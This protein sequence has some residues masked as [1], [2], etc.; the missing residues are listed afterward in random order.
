MRPTFACQRD[1]AF[2]RVDLTVVIAVLLI[3]LVTLLPLM[4]AAVKRR[5]LRI[6]CV[7]NLKQ[8]N[9][10][11]RSWEAEHTNAFPNYPA[12]VSVT[13]GG[14]MELVNRTNA[15]INFAVLDNEFESNMPEVFH[16]PADTG[17]AAATNFNDLPG[18]ISYFINLNANVFS[19]DM[20]V[21]GDDNF[22]TNGIPVESGLLDLSPN[23][24]VT[25]TSG[26]HKFVGN[27]SFADGSVSRISDSRLLKTIE[28]TGS[29]T[30]GEPTNRI[31]IP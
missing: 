24:V 26:R 25:W 18:K 10:A 17:R 20:P 9:D 7:N 31:A 16:C 2:S 22:A 23:T 6:Q 4:L 29:A 3:V 14:T 28:Q 15:W 27:I 30:N 19:S 5:V 12:L 8:I 1:R 13:N 11:F 21:D